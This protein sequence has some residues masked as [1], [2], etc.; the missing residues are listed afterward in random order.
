[1]LMIVVIISFNAFIHLQVKTIQTEWNRYQAEIATRQS[2][3]SELRSQFGYGGGIHLFKNYVL[4]GQQKYA[5]RFKARYTETVKKIRQYENLPDVHEEELAALKSISA[6]FK[7]YRDAIDKAGILIAR[8][9]SIREIDKAIKIS[10]GPALKAMSILDSHYKKLTDEETE[11]INSAMATLLSIF[12]VID[13][14]IIVAFVLMGWELRKSI[15]RPILQVAE[16][17]PKMGDGFLDQ[18]VKM[19]RKDEI[20]KMAQSIDQFSEKLTAIVGD[21]VNNA[22]NLAGASS[23]LVG[24]IDQISGNSQGMTDQASVIAGA[25]EEISAN[26]TTVASAAEEAS[27]NIIQVTSAIEELSTNMENVSGGAG[28][29]TQNM[30]TIAEN[31]GKMSN[32]IDGI[33]SAVEEMSASISEVND[34]SRKAVRI[35]SETNT[36]ATKSLNAMDELGTA[37]NEIGKIVKM[38]GSIANQTNM[39]ALN[40]TIESASAGSAGKGFAVVAEEVKTLA[41]QT[42]ESNNQIGHLVD[43][44]QKLTNQSLTQTRDAVDSIRKVADLNNNIGHAIEEQTR[45]AIEI[46]ESVDSVASFSRQSAENVKKANEEIQDISR[47]VEES[48]QATRASSRNLAEAAT[49]TREIARSAAEVSLGVK[50]V[51]KNIQTIQG[52]IGSVNGEVKDS[53]ADARNLSK[54]ADGLRK[55]VS[56]F[57]LT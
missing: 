51:N 50:D 15:I 10:D 36:V 43:R 27:S 16:V 26:V 33:S 9:Q 52:S 24:S 7:Q 13:I 3:V 41:R 40:A 55:S 56:F 35:S 1:M 5:D 29:V 11:I 54:I 12:V 37:S 30:G 18:K 17:L 39:L 32:D 20:G 8:G 19:L 2:V 38:I 22:E 4:R 57:K 49:G 28:K 47:A 53:N 42:A 44:I 45:T 25:S 6:V 34:S 31:I 23:K 14:A 48:Y 21:I 46:S